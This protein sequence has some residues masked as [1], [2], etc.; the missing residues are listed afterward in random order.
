[1]PSSIRP[2]RDSSLRIRVAPEEVTIRDWPLVD[3]P[4]ASL[5]AIALAAGLSCLLGWAADSLL[6]S[7]AAAVLLAATLWR[8]W[9]PVWYTLS[10]SGISHR[11]LFRRRPIP[12]TAIHQQQIQS[13]G[14]LLVPDAELTPLSPLRGLYLHWGR[15]RA[16]VLA[17]LDYYT[18][19]GFASAHPP[20]PAARAE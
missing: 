15:H 2:T 13:D 6:L 19:C 12:W 7:G 9:L 10:G 18:Q 1:M 5:A 20:T 11:T 3:R 4:L 14:V 16:E 17:H 8:T